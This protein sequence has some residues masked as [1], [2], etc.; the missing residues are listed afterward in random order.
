[1]DSRIANT[2]LVLK[3]KELKDNLQKLEEQRL[4]ASQ[5]AQVAC[6]VLTPADQSLSCPV[7]ATYCLHIVFRLHADFLLLVR[8][9]G[10]DDVRC[11]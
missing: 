5:A 1:M 9:C 2:R 4:S 11:Q 3:L 10:P 6:Q 7:N 8:V